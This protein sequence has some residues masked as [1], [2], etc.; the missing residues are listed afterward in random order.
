MPLLLGKEGHGGAWA[1]TKAGPGG[2]VLHGPKGVR[3]SGTG[4]GQVYF[5]RLPRNKDAP[6]GGCFP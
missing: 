6:V 5:P 4:A 3:K 2:T 1:G